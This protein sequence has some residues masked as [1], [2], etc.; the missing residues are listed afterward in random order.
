MKNFFLLFFFIVASASA[1]SQPTLTGYENF[2]EGTIIK[3]KMVNTEIS[4]LG[5]A[6]GNVTWNF[7]SLGSS[8]N[9]ITREIVDPEST[10]YST[11]FPTAAVAEQN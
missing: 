8:N 1:L 10:S 9:V 3:Y 7:S 4:S 2:T 11:F 6:G 5:E